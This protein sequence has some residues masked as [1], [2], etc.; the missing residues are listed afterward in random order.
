MVTTLLQND[1]RILNY[2]RKNHL[3][4]P[5]TKEYNLR[6][7]GV[8]ETD[9][10]TGLT[11]VIKELLGDKKNGFFI[12]AGSNDGE[13]ISST[14]GF[15][16]FRSWRG[17]CVE[18]SPALQSRWRSK[19]RKAWL[20]NVCLSPK[21]WPVWTNFLHRDDYSVGSKLGDPEDIVDEVGNWTHYNVPCFPIF[22]ILSALNVKEV[23]YFN[24]DV[25]GVEEEVLRTIPFNEILIRTISVE[26]HRN[27][28]D[29]ARK[30]VQ[31]FMTGKGYQTVYIKNADYIFAHNSIAPQK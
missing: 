21:S 19:N 16:K 11:T 17:L 29:S 9:L 31:D 8:G 10:D 26:F 14:L 28:D 12:E 24:L 7:P 15:E 18:A 3:F 30:T 25:E 6:K 22:S 4:P 20:A 5:S 27:A 13:H 23:D 1:S 2:I